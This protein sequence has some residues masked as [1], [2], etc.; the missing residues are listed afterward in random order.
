M[1]SNT[2]VE[3]NPSRTIAQTLA[4]TMTRVLTPAPAPAVATA[5]AKKTGVPYCLCG[6]GN[7]NKVGSRFQAGHDAKVKGMIARVNEN[8]AE[9]GFQFPEVLIEQM[10]A[11]PGLRVASYGS[12]LILSLNRKLARG[13]GFAP[14]KVT[15]TSV[16]NMALDGIQEVQRMIKGNRNRQDILSRLEELES[17]LSVVS[18]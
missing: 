2:V 5:K 16:T 14:A 8:R 12:T 1:N 13:E 18:S 9:V 3:T 7:I 15:K 11:N 10:T 4:R 17:Q 6:C